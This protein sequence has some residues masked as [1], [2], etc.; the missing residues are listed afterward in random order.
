M[1][2]EHLTQSLAQGKCP[3]RGKS[4]YHGLAVRPELRVLDAVCFLSLSD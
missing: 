1:F 3:M 2:V 4:S